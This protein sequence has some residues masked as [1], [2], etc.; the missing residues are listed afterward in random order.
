MAKPTLQSLPGDRPEFAAWQYR[1]AFEKS[2]VAAFLFDAANR[3]CLDAN[4]E[5]EALTG[6][7]RREL[8]DLRLED[9]HPRA[10]RGR[11]LERFQKFL[12]PKGFS[13]DD[14]QLETKDQGRLP[15]AVRGGA[16]SASTRGA[17]SSRRFAT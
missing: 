6:Y 8:L 12:D 4:N 2:S 3:L 10:E 1:A 7:E 9:L 11:V 5:A 15:V 13:Y 16:R 17:S 14:L